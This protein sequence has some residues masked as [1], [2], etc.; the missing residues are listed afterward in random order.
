MKELRDRVQSIANEITEG[1]YDV[2][3]IDPEYVE[4]YGECSPAEHYL[5]DPL[6]IQYIVNSSKEYLGARILVAFGGPTIWINTHEGV[7]EGYWGS[8]SEEWGFTDNL[9]LD[10]FLEE[11]YNCI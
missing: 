6:D 9:G 11:V 7:V 10:E 5:Y 8:D 1:E 2:S 3:S 4:A